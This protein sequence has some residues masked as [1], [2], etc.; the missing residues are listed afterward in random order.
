[1]LSQPAHFTESQQDFVQHVSACAHSLQSPQHSVAAASTAAFSVLL[2][3]AQEAA[4]N[5]AAT[6]ANDINTF[7]MVTKN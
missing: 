5:I 2:L 4:T 1:V 7:F 6:T 3:Q